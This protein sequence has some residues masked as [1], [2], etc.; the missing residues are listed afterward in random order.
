VKIQTE[1]ARVSSSIVLQQMESYSAAPAAETGTVSDDQ[2]NE[3]RWHKRKS[4]REATW[5]MPTAHR[6]MDP[7]RRA[8]GKKPVAAAPGM[9]ES[10]RDYLHQRW[11]AGCRHGRTLFAE[12][13]KLG[14][15]GCYSGLA[16]F[17]SPWR[18]SKAETRRAIRQLRALLEEFLGAQEV[19][20]RDWTVFLVGLNKH[21]SWM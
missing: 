10:F 5:P 12:I 16:K 9:P 17:L 7:A 15:K 6:Q 1:Q 21:S 13:R 11:E 2:A 3:S 14:Y 20:P 18:Q 4:N 8:A 19:S